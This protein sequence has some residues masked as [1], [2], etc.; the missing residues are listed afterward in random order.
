MPISINAL[1]QPRITVTHGGSDYELDAIS[2]DVTLR[3]NVVSH[4]EI[5]VPD[6]KAI[7]SE[8]FEE[9]CDIPDNVK[10]EF[11]YKDKTDTWTQLFGGWIT[12][13]SPSL[14]SEGGQLLHIIA[15]G[16]EQAL[17]N[18]L[19]HEEYGSQSANSSLNT[20]KEILTD[21][22]KGIIPKYVA[23]VMAS[24]TDSG[25][26]IDTTKVADLTSD[27]RYL[28]FPGK[29]AIKCLN[30]LVDLIGAANTPDAGAHW[31]CI[32]SGTTTYL[33][34]ATV[35]VH[36]N[37]PADVWPTWWNTDQ[38]GST[39]EVTQDMIL[40]SFQKKR[41]DGNYVLYAGNFRRPV[42]GD[43]W[44]EGN[45]SEYGKD[46]ETGD[47]VVED[48]TTVY[49]IGVKSIRIREP[50]NAKWIVGY[51]PFTADM[52][53]D[54]TQIESR[55]T[56][57]HIGFYV[58]RNA[59]VYVGGAGPVRPTIW[60]GTTAYAN[61][62]FFSCDLLS[63]GYLSDADKWY[64]VSLPIGNYHKVEEAT[65]WEWAQTNSPNWNDIDWI[66]FTCSA[67]AADCRLYIDGLRIEGFLQRA[68]YDS[69][70]YATQ[71]CKM[72]FIR[73]NVPKDDTLVALNDVGEMAQFCK[74]EL[75]RAITAPTIG[76]I[77]IP[78][79]EQIRGGQLAHIHYAKTSSGFRIDKN[80]RITTVKHHFDVKSG[81]FSFLDLTDDVKNSRGIGPADAY[82]MLMKATSPQF[83]DRV[84][85]SLITG[86]LNVAQAIL[87]KNYDTSTW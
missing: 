18:M 52:N 58:R 15:L 2:W 74:A 68:A 39:L 43:K 4:A 81:A 60:L 41:S 40:S 29:P 31:T 12:D 13:L 75:R 27:F 17:V 85:G 24:A 61:A 19:V 21:S 80:M 71:K 48:E 76:Q 57:P 82:E 14:D 56:V 35:G 46:S 9:K 6:S 44:T 53:F 51:Y 30:D 50:T 45:A 62:K 7:Y 34:L 5:V 63:R 70:K 86:D 65:D 83:Q 79:Q 26:S 47:G 78:L 72:V 42:D 73:D 59:N 69:A 25:Y 77:S 55:T 8:I 28:V 20:I 16:Y 11:R 66:G 54:I 1:P 67:S 36:E 38:T 22:S 49:K 64:H 87:G 84:F 23:K 3:E 37:P 10:V 33:C 32:P